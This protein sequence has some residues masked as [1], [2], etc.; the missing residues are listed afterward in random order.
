[1]WKKIRT[2]I[3]RIQIWKEFQEIYL[4]F[5]EKNSLKRIWQKARGMAAKDES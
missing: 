2:A 1:M 3:E 5:V 4:G